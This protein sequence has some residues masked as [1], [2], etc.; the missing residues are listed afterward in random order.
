MFRECEYGRVVEREYKSL[1]QLMRDLFVGDR[2]L[3]KR[4]EEQVR[5]STLVYFDGPPYRLLFYV[6][7]GGDFNH[8]DDVCI[9]GHEWEYHFDRL[10]SA[11]C[12][13]MAECH[14]LGW[15]SDWAANA[16]AMRPLGVIDS[17]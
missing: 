1:S 16:E 13:G 14:C 6:G 17:S 3:R 15:I 9:C 5:E 7:A 12:G 8:P 4:I 11:A 2:L 10:E